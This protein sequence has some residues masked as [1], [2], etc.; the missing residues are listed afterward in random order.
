MFGYARYPRGYQTPAGRR[1]AI[2]VCK[3]TMSLNE[4][5]RA[6]RRAHPS[7]RAGEFGGWALSRW[8]LSCFARWSKPS[9]NNPISYDRN[10]EGNYLYVSLGIL[11][12]HASCRRAIGLCRGHAAEQAIERGGPLELPYLLAHAVGAQQI[13]HATAGADNA[14]SD[15]AGRQLA[16][17]GM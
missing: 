9:A 5:A 15:A 7:L 4:D 3:T 12:F 6:L 16:M 13:S 8:L 14:Q 11:W 10:V 2:L 17:Q 1:P